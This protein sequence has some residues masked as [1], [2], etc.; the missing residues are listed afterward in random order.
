LQKGLQKAQKERPA[1]PPSI[2]AVHLTQ[3]ANGPA[4]AAPAQSAT[5]NNLDQQQTR[6]QAPPSQPEVHKEHIQVDEKLLS[7]GFSVDN[8]AHVIK[9]RITN[10]NTG[11]VVREFE[12]KGLPQ[13]HHEPRTKGVIVDDQT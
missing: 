12:L 2:D 11:E 3:L 13:A 4:V 6:K 7:L 1:M 5:Q 10:Q 8:S 9:I